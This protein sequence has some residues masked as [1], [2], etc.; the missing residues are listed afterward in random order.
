MGRDWQPG[1]PNRLREIL[2]TAEE[3]ELPSG[4]FLVFY[5]SRLLVLDSIIEVEIPSGS[6]ILDANLLE[7]RP[8]LFGMLWV[9]I[10]GNLYN[11]SVAYAWKAVA[12]NGFLVRTRS[13]N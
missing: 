9:I 13:S 1:V 4:Q 10:H 2:T 11:F 12:E 7:V 5:A 6:R 8:D 3:P